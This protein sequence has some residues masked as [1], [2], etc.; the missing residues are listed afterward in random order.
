MRLNFFI[1][2]SPNSFFYTKSFIFIFFQVFYLYLFFSFPNSFLYTMCFIWDSF[3]LDVHVPNYI[4]YTKGFIWDSFLLDGH[5]LFFWMCMCPII[6]FI[7]SVLYGILFFWMCMC[8]I[9]FA[10]FGKKVFIS[11]CLVSVCMSLNLFCFLC[12]NIRV[13][14]QIYLKIKHL[15]T[16]CSTL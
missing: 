4:L 16:L 15:K 8:P 10:W 12:K 14:C 1:F 6:F 5:I 11:V 3:L 2:S 9:I 13:S 7:Q